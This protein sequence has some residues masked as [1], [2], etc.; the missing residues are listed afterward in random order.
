MHFDHALRRVIGLAGLAALISAAPA[1][2]VV[3]KEP[4][5]PLSQ[6]EFFKPDL[7]ISTSALPLSDMLVRLP[8]RAAWDSYLRE[9]AS[10][11]GV[12]AFIDPRSG[13]AASIVGVFPLLPG[14]GEGNAV[15]LAEVSAR[16]GRPVDAIG[17]EAVG[18]LVVGFVRA[19]EAI[20]GIDVRQLGPVSARVANADL[21]HV[22]IP[23]AFKGIPVRHGQ[24]VAAISHGNLVVIGTEGWGNV[25]IDTTPALTGEQAMDAGFAFAYGRQPEDV[26]LREPRLEVIPFAPAEFQRGEGFAGAVGSGYGHRLAW[27]FE[28]QRPPEGERWEVIVDAKNGEILSLEDKNHYIIKQATGGVYP[29][30]NTE[31]CPT[32]ETCGTMQL[33]WPMPWL[34]TGLP[35]PNDFANSAG[36][37]DYT[38]GTATSTLNG[39]F[40]RINDNCGPI[41]LSSATGD[42]NF[43]GANGQHD[44]VTPGFGG[45]GN[46]SASRSA[47]YEVNKIKEQAR[48]WLPANTWLTGVLQTNVN[49]V[50]T[51][52][53]FYSGGT[54]NF[55]R[56]GAGGTGFC[57]NTGE[58]A[59]VFDHEWGHGMDDFDT[60][61]ALSASSEGYA[62]IA[63]IYR[64]QASC[65]GHGFNDTTNPTACGITV[66]GTGRNRNENQVGGLHCD[67]DC[68]GVRDADWAKHTPNTPDTAANFVCG[69]CT[70]SGG[71]C[72]R[73]THCAAAPSRQ[74]AWDLVARDLRAAPFNMSS[75]TAFI[76][77]N[78]VFYQGSGLIGSWHTCTCPTTSNGCGATNAYL[79]WLAADDDNGNLNDGTPHMTAIFA[80]M[81]RHD[82][83][84]A[85]PAP[86]NSGCAAGPSAASTLSGTAGNNSVTLN[87]TA[88]AGATRYWVFRTEGHNGCNLGK[89]LIAE[90]ATPTLTYTD[91]QVANGRAYS[92][93]V[94]P[95]GASSA[96]F[97]PASNC[98]TVTPGSTAADFGLTCAPASF[99]I[100]QGGS[101][102]STCTVQSQ[103][104]FSAAVTLSCAGLPAGV[105]CTYVPPAVTPAPNGAAPSTLTVTVGAAVPAG[106]YNF[107]AQGVSGALTHTFP[108][109][110]TVTAVSVAPFALAVDTAGN[111]VYQPNETVVVAPSWLNTGA[112]AI[113]LNGALTNHTGPAGPTY[114]IPDAAAS[115][116]TIPATSNASCTATGNCYSVANTAATRPSTHWDSTAVETVTP[117]ATAKTW[118]LHVGNSFTDVPPSNPFFRFIEI[119]L[120]RPVTGGCTQTAYC[121]ANST[122][123]EQMAVFVLLSK[124]PTGYV[125]PAC[126]AGSEVFN[127]VPATSPFCRW[128]E[129]LSRRG[130]ISGCGSG[131]YCPQ[132]PVTREQMSIFVLRTLDPTFTPPPCVPPNLY[133]DVPETNPFCRWIEDLTNRGVVSGCGGGNYCP[134]QP[135]TRE[136]MGVFLAVTFGLTLYGL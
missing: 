110:L 70:A 85:T 46:T 1:G 56:S 88:V 122:T 12:S 118:T 116:G 102:P 16:L 82:M 98:L 115:Y 81:N 95:A 6:K 79:Q 33:G 73:Q 72:G 22:R 11:G 24:L 136:Q 127:D 78:K 86:Q 108:L 58:I 44:C 40:V 99:T 26:L 18:Q 9:R 32:P 93:N 4:L 29:L 101:A 112:S 123:R 75:E 125:P 97:G 21:W 54:I 80:A 36:V 41:S 103:N 109:S 50:S 119:L 111:G 113:A 57:R 124:E 59:A 65:V 71:L 23:Q 60:G 13:A 134:G 135:V 64:L 91:T 120:H 84:C 130:V 114:S 8:N 28:F 126:V 3:P 47:F 67:T 117:T 2:A 20:L 96:C 27:T 51:C 37:Y 76:V 55:Y 77:G 43:G 15:T 100:N 52:N 121:P 42:L 129:E 87:W 38:A 7:Y 63:G 69:Q 68:S 133:L 14:R 104:A 30:T 17:A 48:G 128:I 132:N 45:A 10:G 53:A 106:T 74:M 31:I 39:R 105:T 5:S 83:A 19:H 25:A 34:N 62:D 61:G 35:A 107:Q 131:A 49:I 94:V 90:V 89:A 92:Y 66:D